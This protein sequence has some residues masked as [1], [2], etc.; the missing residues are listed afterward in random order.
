MGAARIAKMDEFY[1]QLTDVEKELR[2]YKPHFRGKVVYC[3]ADDPRVSAFFKY[4]ALNFEA[5]GLKKLITTCYRSQAPDLFSKNNSD[6]AVFLEYEGD[7]NSNRV[8]DPDEIEVLPLTGDGD[9]RSEEC[10]NLLNQADIIVTNPPFSLFHQY[11]SQLIKHDKKFAIIGNPNATSYKQIFPLIKDGK[12]W[13]GV[14]PS[15]GENQFFETT[16][17]FAQ[18]VAATKPQGAW[19]RRGSN[20]KILVGMKTVWYTNLD[21]P[22]RHVDLILYRKYNPT[23]YPS[24]D[25]FNAIEVGKVSEIPANYDGDMGVPLTFL[26]NWNPDQ[27]EIV[28]ITQSWDKC[29]TK[30]YPGQIQVSADGSESQV[31]KLNDGAAIKVAAPPANKTYYKVEGEM[32]VKAYARI[33]I[34]RRK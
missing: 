8:P 10:I 14:K 13:W 15:G 11:V 19:W 12:L 17:A 32:F 7:K 9:F 6:H 25:N 34:R 18:R 28:G 3:N 31:T 24:Y 2:H 33:L 4:F 29:A 22:K 20:G 1:T 21:F 26:D 23:D 16:D 5:L 30:I 27:F